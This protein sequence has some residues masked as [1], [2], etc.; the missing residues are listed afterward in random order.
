MQ[1]CGSQPAE[2]TASNPAGAWMFCLVN[3]VCCQ[4]V[5]TERSLVLRSPTDCDVS[6]CDRG[7]LQR[8][9]RPI[10]TVEPPKRRVFI[11][12]YSAYAFVLF[13]QNFIASLTTFVLYTRRY[14][15]THCPYQSFY[16][17]VQSSTISISSS[18]VSDITVYLRTHKIFMWIF[19]HNGELKND[20]HRM[21]FEW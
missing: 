5:G 15:T 8:M 17:S 7:N 9:S 2:N 1:V 4:A 19:L 12:V 10:S 18:D 21:L 16:K 20:F 11:F 13:I 6:E 3:A 14:R